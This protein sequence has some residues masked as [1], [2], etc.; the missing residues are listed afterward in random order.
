MRIK[1]GYFKNSR[2]KTLNPGSN[3]T[4]KHPNQKLF[5]L[6]QTLDCRGTNRQRI[7]AV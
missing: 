4:P 7:P 1:I 6:I 5:K 3:G 2:V